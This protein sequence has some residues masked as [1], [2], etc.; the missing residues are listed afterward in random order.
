MYLIVMEK[1]EQDKPQIIR[2][3]ETIKTGVG[4]NYIEMKKLSQI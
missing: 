3:M 2:G 4:I 1:Q